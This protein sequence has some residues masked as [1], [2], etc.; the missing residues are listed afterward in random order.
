[1]TVVCVCVCVCV[2]VCVYVC[3][4]QRNMYILERNNFPLYVLNLLHTFK[5]I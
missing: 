5:F 4:I 3:D 2:Y 1:M